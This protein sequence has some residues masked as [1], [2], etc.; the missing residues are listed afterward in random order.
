MDGVLSRRDLI[1]RS[2]L[3]PLCAA[4]GMGLAGGG[5]SAFAQT[6]INRVG[7]P[8]LKI[9]LNA[10][11]FSKALN[12]HIKD[13][14]PG[15]TL[16]DLLEFCAEHDFDAVDPTGYFFPGYPEV[17]SDSFVNEFKRRAFLLGLDISG[18]GVRNDFCHPDKAKRA[19]DVQHIKQWIEVAAKMG[20]P[21]IRI[22]ATNQRTGIHDGYTWDQTAEW[23]A[24][25]I[26]Q[27]ADYGKKYGVIV[28]VQNHT[29]FIKTADHVL[30]ILR[31]VDSPW[32]GLI[33]DTGCFRSE[34]PYEDMAR[35]MPCTV[36]F[37]IKEK[38]LGEES[39]VRTDLKRLFRIIKGAGYRGYIPI[40]TLSLKGE[41]YDPKVRVARFLKE[42]R[43]ALAEPSA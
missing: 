33:L 25:D 10:F 34:D 27:C 17:P 38:L 5:A 26:K 21:V 37:Q 12:D 22:F 16:F 15:M 41:E 31:M 4:T 23:M 24:E 28:G 32:C 13:R 42:V 36:N 35:V 3:L 9:S 6:P 19:A 14:G 40:E 18:T 2:S 11:S 30:K 20:A 7:G 43:E 39:N 1:K 29:Y 8:K